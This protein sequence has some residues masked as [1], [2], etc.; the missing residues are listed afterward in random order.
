MGRNY[1]VIESISIDLRAVQVQHAARSEH[2]HSLTHTHIQACRTAARDRARCTNLKISTYF[3]VNFYLFGAPAPFLQFDSLLH[4][5][6]GVRRGDCYAMCLCSQTRAGEPLTGRRLLGDGGYKVTRS[7]VE[8]PSK[9]TTTE[10]RVRARQSRR[11]KKFNDRYTRLVGR[12]VDSSFSG[13]GKRAILKEKT[14]PLS[15]CRQNAK[16]MRA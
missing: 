14:V 4:A 3:L 12:R 1:T 9:G 13:L 10:E 15:R 8:T 2:A 6:V 5:G 7:K 16:A 11:I